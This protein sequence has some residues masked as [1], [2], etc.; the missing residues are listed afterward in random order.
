MV[1]EGWF[2]PPAGLVVR[3]YPDAIMWVRLT[4]GHSEKQRQDF[5]GTRRNLIHRESYHSGAP[6][7]SGMDT[8]VLTHE[9]GPTT[10]FS[11]LVRGF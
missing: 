10:L 2:S 1:P 4:R 3:A 7:A 6:L 8:P 9:V 5:R 11:A